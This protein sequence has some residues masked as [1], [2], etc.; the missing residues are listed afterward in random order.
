MET[1]ATASF[2]VAAAVWVGAIVF[3]SAIV[4]PAV[5]GDLDE[6]QARSFL[7]T[8]FPRFF[9]LG[10]VCGAVMLTSVGLFGMLGGWSATA[11]TLAAGAMLMT[12]LAVAS[13]ALVP[14][15]N[16]ARDAGSAG[17]TRFRRLHG[18]SVMLTLAVLLVGIALLVIVALHAARGL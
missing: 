17:A 4:A 16:G 11:A 12:L 7:R 14:H 15:I 13:L 8:L 18:A 1:I 5:F 9:R 6:T 10:I 3:Q 2:T